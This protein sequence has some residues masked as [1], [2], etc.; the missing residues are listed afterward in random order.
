MSDFTKLGHTRRSNMMYPTDLWPNGVEVPFEEFTVYKNKGMFNNDT[1]MA[2]ASNWDF[3]VIPIKRAHRI[4]MS[5]TNGEWTY[6]L[7]ENLNKGPVTAIQQKYDV[8]TNALNEPYFGKSLRSHRTFS[9][10]TFYYYPIH[11]AERNVV[12]QQVRQDSPDNSYTTPLIPVHG[13]SKLHTSW[14]G[15]GCAQWFGE[16]KNHLFSR[17]YGEEAGVYTIP[18]G[19]YYC[20]LKTYR[21]F[22][23]TENS[24]GSSTVYW[25]E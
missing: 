3:M 21:W 14:S 18:E 2:D 17:D 10:I 20:Q 16:D 15:R 22:N 1:T 12:F 13:Y 8:L 9:G 19:A 7:D 5:D 6:Y 4:K 11:G 23:E 25:L 24:K